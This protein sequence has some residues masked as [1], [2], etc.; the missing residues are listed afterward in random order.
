MCFSTACFTYHRVNE[1]PLQFQSYNLSKKQMWCHDQSF[2]L[3]LNCLFYTQRKPSPWLQG[4]SD[5]LNTYLL[6][7]E[8]TNTFAWAIVEFNS[9]TSPSEEACSNIITVFYSQPCACNVRWTN[10]N[11]SKCNRVIMLLYTHRAHQLSNNTVRK[12]QSQHCMPYCIQLFSDKSS[13][14]SV[15]VMCSDGEHRGVCMMTGMHVG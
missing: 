13:R 9:R 3:N 8:K 11:T 5:Y 10:N 2:F 14:Q 1:H 7:H 12:N 15:S 6:I 4:S